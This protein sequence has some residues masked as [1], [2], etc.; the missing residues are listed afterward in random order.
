MLKSGVLLTHQ[1]YPICF[2]LGICHSIILTT[3]YNTEGK[4]S[5]CNSVLL[6]ETIDAVVFLGRMDSPLHACHA[7]NFD[8]LNIQ[9][10]GLLPNLNQVL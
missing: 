5:I 2:L 3:D 4:Y 10:S 7:V 9:R 6:A 8:L 1:S